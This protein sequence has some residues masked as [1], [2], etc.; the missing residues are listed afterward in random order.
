MLTIFWAVLFL[1]LSPS[2]STVL[3]FS[4]C[5]VPTE[6]HRG[7]AQCHPALPSGRA[8]GSSA[9]AHYTLTATWFSYLCIS[10]VEQ[11]LQQAGR[12]SLFISWGLMKFLRSVP[13]AQPRPCRTQQPRNKLCFPPQPFLPPTPRP[14]AQA[15]IW[16][17]TRASRPQPCLLFI[18][19]E[20]RRGVCGLCLLIAPSVNSKVCPA[21]PLPLADRAALSERLGAVGEASE[22]SP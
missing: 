13:R 7:A 6:Q 10:L 5:F 16:G 2:P 4:A 8:H 1:S 15:G 18:A 11:V 9:P 17:G 14:R 12:S 3:D 21:L 19:A 22:P 20:V